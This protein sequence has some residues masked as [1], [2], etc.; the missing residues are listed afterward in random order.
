MPP[1]D[2]SNDDESLSQTFCTVEVF[3][4]DSIV[5]ESIQINNERV[6][7]LVKDC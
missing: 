5:L 2:S 1:F 6:T 3:H 7:K 4:E